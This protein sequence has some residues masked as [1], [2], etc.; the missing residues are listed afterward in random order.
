LENI[1]YFELLR[2]DFQVAIG[3]S[4]ALEVDFVATRP[5]KTAYY[6]VTASM[7]DENTRR[8]E[9]APLRDI[10]DNYEKTVLSMDRTPVTDF[11][12]IRNVNL[13]DFLLET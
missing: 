6:Q 5:D 8:R 10:G 12:G 9:L 3:K 7:L 4:G 11:D 13:L 2:R 1:V